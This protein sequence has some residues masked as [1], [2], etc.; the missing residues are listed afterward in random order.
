[1]LRN[2]PVN[3]ELTERGS[4]RSSFVVF[5]FLFFFQA[6][7]FLL[8]FLSVFFLVIF[9]KN[10][11]V[12]WM[13]LRDLELGVAL[14]ATQDFALF[15]FIFVQ[16]DFCVAFGTASHGSALLFQIQ[17]LRNTTPTLAR[18]ISNAKAII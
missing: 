13:S 8:R 12:H 3:K 2:S 18:R 1:M 6:R 15:H 17:G 9:G 7:F 10:N 14:G 11:E 5:F 4:Q 16:V